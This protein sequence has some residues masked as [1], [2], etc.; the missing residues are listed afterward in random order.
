MIY[1]RTMTEELTALA[2]DYPVISVMG[3]RQSGKTTLVRAAFPDKPYANLE[4][5]DQRLL[6]ATDPRGFLA[7]FEKGGIIDEVQHVPELLSYIQAIVDESYQPGMFIITG[8]HQMRLH[9]VMSQ[10]LAGRVGILN[11]YPLTLNE[12]RHA[13]I[14]LSLDEQIYRGFYPR[15][16]QH[17]LNPTKAYRNYVQTYLEK[18]VRRLSNISDLIQFQNFMKLCAGRIGQVLDYVS[19]GNDLGISGNTVKKW[20]SIL[21][22]S[23]VVFRLKPYFENF[24]KRVIKSSKLYFTDVGLATYLLDIEETKQLTRDPMRGHLVENLVILEL[25]KYRHNR[26]LDP[27]LYYYRDNHKN[28][29][30][31]IIKHSNQLIPVEIKSAQTFNKDFLKGLKFYQNLVGERMSTGY[32]IYAGDLNQSVSGFQLLN[33]RDT[34]RIYLDLASTSDN[35]S[36]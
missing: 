20:I 7:Q 3:P 25:S 23:Y 6:A 14:E 33:Y 13:G 24:G 28:E 35:H 31:V 26:G 19:L 9:E 30:D 32:V 10:S 2:K 22:A 15:I 27:N 12:L 1:E 4:E 34:T 36:T 5:P 8:S 29:I 11:L 21:E 18:D 17:D 16:Y